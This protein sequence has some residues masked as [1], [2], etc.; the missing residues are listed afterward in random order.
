MIAFLQTA[1]AGEPPYLAL[2]VFL[3]LTVVLIVADLW[4]GFRG[5]RRAHVPCALITVV[6][7]ALAIFNAEKVG[8]YWRFEALYLKIHLAAAYAGTALALLTVVT[9]VLHFFNKMGR[10]W[11]KRIALLFVVFVFLSTATALLMFQHGVRR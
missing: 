10:V 8:G 11:H 7:F 6:C 3:C 4:T 2:T 1:P 9:G 5:N